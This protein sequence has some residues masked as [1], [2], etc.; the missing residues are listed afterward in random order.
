MEA[1]DNEVRFLDQPGNEERK[2]SA[3]RALNDQLTGWG[4]ELLDMADSVLVAVDEIDL[5]DDYPE[6]QATEAAD[7]AVPVMSWDIMQAVSESLELATTEPEIGPAFDGSPTPVNI[8]AGVL[9]DLCS[10]IAHSRLA[11]RQAEAADAE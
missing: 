10:N 7:G 8:A 1:T 5:S 9:Y 11:E 6:D 4:P 2:R 3:I